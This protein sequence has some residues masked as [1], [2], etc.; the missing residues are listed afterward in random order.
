MAPQLGTTGLKSK[1][2]EPKIDKNLLKILL[3]F[4]MIVKHDIY[5]I[6]GMQKDLLQ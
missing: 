4:R 3:K 1:W 6:F 5:C 2:I